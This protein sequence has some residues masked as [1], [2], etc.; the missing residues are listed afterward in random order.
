MTGPV[1]L[2]AEPIL[3]SVDVREA[4]NFY[5]D[6][7]DFEG[8]VTGDHPHAI[9]KRDRVVIHLW[10]TE[11]P[12]LPRF[13]SCRLIVQNIDA[14]HDEYT[15]L[16]IVHPEGELKKQPWGTEEFSIVDPEGNM[17]TFVQLP[18]EPMQTP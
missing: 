12:N 11:D 5:E 2:A 18:Q 16:G 17:I 13:S 7:L 8:I 14:L 3:P 9:L 15:D 6:V 4:L 10:Q 1:F